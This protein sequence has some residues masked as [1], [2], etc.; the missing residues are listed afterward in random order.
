VSPSVY[1][2]VS[3][4]VLALAPSFPFHLERVR[5]RSIR[6]SRWRYAR[7]RVA[8]HASCCAIFDTKVR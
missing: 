3:F 5:M 1:R 6:S 2:K 8:L 7:Q 4:A